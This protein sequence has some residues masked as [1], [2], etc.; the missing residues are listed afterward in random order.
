VSTETVTLSNHD[1]GVALT[2]IVTSVCGP[3]AFVAL[4][5][6]HPARLAAGS[7]DTSLAS[8]A[9][10]GAFL[11]STYDLAA[12]HLLPVDLPVGVVTVVVGGAYLLWLIAWKLQRTH[13]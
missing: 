12:Q 4:A 10:L 8:A 6:P 2:A 13:A 7:A 1:Q 9:A 11:L 3:I 5:A